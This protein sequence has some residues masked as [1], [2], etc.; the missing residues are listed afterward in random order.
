LSSQ[1]SEQ[2]ERLL[3]REDLSSTEAISAIG[4]LVV[5]QLLEY[6]ESTLYL[7]DEGTVSIAAPGEIGLDSLP[8]E[9][10]I[11]TLISQGWAD[12]EVAK[13]LRGRDARLQRR[14]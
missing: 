6:G 3:R 14:G 11:N 5:R 8:E 9:M 1:P 13:Y 2:E 4:L 10:A 7:D 12:E